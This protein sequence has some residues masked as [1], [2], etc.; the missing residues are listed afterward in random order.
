VHKGQ[1]AVERPAMRHDAPYAR[2]IYL[3][4]DPLSLQGTLLRRDDGFY[5]VTGSEDLS[6]IVGKAT[7]R[8]TKVQPGEHVLVVVSNLPVI[9]ASAI[10]KR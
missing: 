1:P 9:E 5:A 6:L 10:E 3:L 4:A 8:D 2:S 7:V